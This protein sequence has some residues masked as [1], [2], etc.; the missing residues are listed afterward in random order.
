M[1]I[2]DIAEE[3]TE[4]FF[5]MFKVKLHAVNLMGTGDIAGSSAA[6]KNSLGRPG[7]GF[8]GMLLEER[9]RQ[10][11]NGFKG[12]NL[13]GLYSE[14]GDISFVNWIVRRLIREQTKRNIGKRLFVYG[15]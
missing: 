13:S 5:S 9:N 2:A 14:V 15:V 1:I 3:M 8:Y 4:T 12:G 7:T 11:W 6:F 10:K